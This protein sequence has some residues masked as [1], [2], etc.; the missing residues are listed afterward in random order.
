MRS[1]QPTIIQGTHT[2][3]WL[4]KSSQFVKKIKKKKS[5]HFWVILFSR[6]ANRTPVYLQTTYVGLQVLV[7]HFAYTLMSL[8]QH[9]VSPKLPTTL[10]D[11]AD[12]DLPGYELWFHNIDIVHILS[13]EIDVSTF[14]DAL[15]K[16][17]QL[18]P[19]VAGQLRCR[20]G[21]WS[22]SQTPPFPW[23]LIINQ[24]QNPIRCCKGIG[25]FRTTCS[26]C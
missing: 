13:T 12:V 9:L 23:T 15:S 19:H 17:L 3:T 7:P 14:K 2:H 16:A 1:Q 5:R 18:F 4:W 20:D 8:V 11:Q 22:S 21:R 10:A 6:A 26:H 25:S 24:T